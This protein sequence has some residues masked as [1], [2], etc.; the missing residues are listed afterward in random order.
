[1]KKFLFIQGFIYGSANKGGVEMKTS[2]EDQIRK[3]DL[4]IIY[5]NEKKDELEIKR[6]KPETKLVFLR[7][8]EGNIEEDIESDMCGILDDLNS[9]EIFME[10]L[11]KRITEFYKIK[12]EI[13]EVKKEIQNKED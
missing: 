6:R 13:V 5:L 10:N 11:D 8:D 2:L 1:M 9:L 3:I 4:K 7:E 12:E